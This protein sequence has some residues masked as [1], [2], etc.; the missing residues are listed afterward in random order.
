MWISN[1]FIHQN[2]MKSKQRQRIGLL[3][4]IIPPANA[5]ILGKRQTHDYS[6][7]FHKGSLASKVEL[8][9]Y[10]DTASDQKGTEGALVNACNIGTALMVVNS[11]RTLAIMWSITGL[12]PVFLCLM[13]SLRND[14]ASEM[15]RNLQGINLISQNSSDV[16]CEFLASSIEAW[17][18]ASITR[19]F[20][21]DKTP[22]LV[23]FEVGPDRCDFNTSALRSVVLCDSYFAPTND[24]PR[25]E[26]I[27]ELWATFPNFSLREAVE[28]I[29]NVNDI[30]VGSIV[31]YDDLTASNFANLTSDVTT[32]VNYT[33]V[34]SFDFSFSIKEA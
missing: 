16:T 13:S 31:F 17:T 15:T 22:S 11:Y 24:V 34:S 27:C 23:S 30:R 14:S 9:K 3:A 1:T 4:N 7:T 5:S 18:A 26:E 32:M 20:G 2:V 29:A 28:E 33:V 25:M 8:A 21:D 19:S 12:F 6:S 10:K